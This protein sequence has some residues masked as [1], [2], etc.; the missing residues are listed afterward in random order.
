MEKYISSLPSHKIQ[1]QKN[2]QEFKLQDCSLKYVEKGNGELVLCVHGSVSD[3]RTW[4]KQLDVFSEKY[5]TI[6]YSRR[7][8]WPNE[9]I[10]DDVDYSLLQHVSDLEEILKALNQPVILIG[11]SYGAFICL[12]AAMG[13]QEFIKGLV[14]AEPP[15]ITLYVSNI[16]KPSEILKLLLSKP[17]TALALIKFGANGMQPAIKEVKRKNREKAI[18]VFGRATLGNDTFEN[19]SNERRAQ[20]MDN[21]IDAEFIG[22]GFPPI[23]QDQ[24]KKIN[25]PTLLLAGQHSPALFQ[26]LLE[27]LEELIPNS[28]RKIIPNASHI[29]HEDNYEEYNTIVLAFIEKALN[30]N[31]S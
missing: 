9:K 31:P 15:A 14:L 20:V 3:Y 2:M 21:F 30:S 12:L 10:P 23:N 17:K 8:H 11:H 24:L 18:E 6:C 13:P 19:L 1:N 7:F 27:R 4:N 26:L 5:R 22:P 28:E 16:P 29:S 25:V